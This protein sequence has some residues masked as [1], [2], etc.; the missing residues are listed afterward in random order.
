MASTSFTIRPAQIRDLLRITTVCLDGL[1]G[2][3]TFTFLW[4]YRHQYPED[5]YS[6]GF[7][8][9]KM[10]LVLTK[11]ENWAIGHQHAR[12]DDD[13]NRLLAFRSTM[14]AVHEKYWKTLFPQ[15][16]H[17]VLLVTDPEFWGRGAGT[18]LTR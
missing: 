3:P 11:A 14:Q 7:R 2:M 1:A 8:D 4:R 10:I 16:C 6:S 12:R 13:G 5:S 9:S 15:N 18:M 17:L